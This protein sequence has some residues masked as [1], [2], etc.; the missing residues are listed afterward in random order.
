MDA[1]YCF[2]TK[3]T[4][5]CLYYFQCCSFFDKIKYLAMCYNCAVFK[6]NFHE[7]S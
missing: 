2:S 7:T 3:A 4:S 6:V 5:Y 1:K